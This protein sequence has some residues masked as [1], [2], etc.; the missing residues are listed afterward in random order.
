MAIARA[1]ISGNSSAPEDAVGTWIKGNEVRIARVQCRISD[2]TD[3]GDLTVS[4]LTVAAGLLA[5]LVA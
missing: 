3:Q 4:K 5:D 1:A 2:L